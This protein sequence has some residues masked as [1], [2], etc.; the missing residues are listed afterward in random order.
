MRGRQRWLI[1]DT[2]DVE[3]G[4]H[5]GVLGGLTLGVVEVGGDGDDS[6]LDVLAH[7][8]LGSLL[9]LSE[10]EATHLRRRVLLSLGLE[11]SIAVGVLDNLV[12]HLLDI[13][14][15]L[16]IGELAADEALGSEKSV[17]WVDNGLAL[18]SNTNEALAFL[19]EANDG[20]SGAA[21]WSRISTRARLLVNAAKTHLPSSQ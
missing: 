8:G 3:S 14:L 15:D 5:T 19:G 21:T 10:D 17:L 11:P 4:N 9:H 2:E 18:G 12:G 6:V 1:D 7:V 16:A 13:A 20:G